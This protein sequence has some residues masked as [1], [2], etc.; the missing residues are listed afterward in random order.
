MRICAGSHA[1]VVVRLDDVRLAGAG[2]GRL[3][4][5]GVDGPLRQPV[6]ALELAC[7]LVEHLDE[8]AADDLALLLGVRDAGQR[9]E[10]TI[11]GVDADHADAHVLREGGHH[12]VAFAERSRP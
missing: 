10:E 12:L 3:D 7:F 11:L 9:R 8:Q 5:V 6:D 4:D 1:D 2:T